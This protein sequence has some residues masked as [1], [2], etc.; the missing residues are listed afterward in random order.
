MTK[1][2]VTIA[3]PVYNRYLY[4]EEAIF[5]VLSQSYNVNIIVVDN[6]SEHDKFERFIKELNMPNVK[7]FRNE[8]NVGMVE[9]WNKCI[10]YCDTEWLSILHDDDWISPSYVS[11][12]SKMIV[13]F[14]KINIFSVHCI[15]DSS[16][17]KSNFSISSQPKYYKIKKNALFFRNLSPFPG[18]CFKFSFAKMIGSFNNELFPSAD[19]D[20]WIRCLL[21]G[22][23]IHND[24]PLAFYRIS[25]NQTTVAVHREIIDKTFEIRKK[26]YYNQST[27]NFLLNYFTLYKLYKSYFKKIGRINL[28]KFNNP[29]IQYYFYFF[30]YLDMFKLSFIFNFLLIIQLKFTVVNLNKSWN[31]GLN[32]YFKE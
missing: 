32:N 13:K 21:S 31:N 7:Y 12:I 10:E 9:N 18:I 4:F 23:I 20:Y 6:N 1:N 24:L 19:Y 11:E 17:N 28:I 16:V 2:N 22:T 3:I 25:D 5:S 26:H 30:Y 15:C 8:Y 29:S 27:F 14:P